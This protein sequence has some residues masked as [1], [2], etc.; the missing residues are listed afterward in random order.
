MSASAQVLALSGGVG[1]AKLS[2]GLQRVLEPGGLTVLVN[3]GDDFWHMGLRI[4][5]DL[6]T[7]L[8]TLAG[9]A[10]TTQGWGRAEESFGVLQ[11]I[12]RLGFESWFR[13]GDRDL[14]IHLERTRR[15][16]QGESLT[17]IT[18]ALATTFGVSTQILP[19]CDESVST[20]LLTP[21]GWLGFQ[22]YFVRQRCEPTVTQLEFLGA[23]AAQVST[24]LE[25]CLRATELRVIVLCPSNPWL[26]IDPILA[27]PG[28]RARLRAAGVP[29]VAVSPLVGGRAVKGPTAKLMREL[30]QAVEHAAIA[31]HYADFIDGLLIDHGDISELTAAGLAGL[32][33]QRVRAVPTL[34]R[35]LDDRESL[36]RA[37]LAFADDL[38]DD[39]AMRCE[40]GI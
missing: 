1:G 39:A 3:T 7:T 28:L 2:L 12:T 26:S 38:R 10:D 6:D 19:M 36:A 27:V 20:R 29:I 34:M 9:V 33:P 25:H 37:V 11:E 35:T 32:P 14:A 16:Q 13:L 18:A 30:G 5:P 24:A 4:C 40:G 15:L 22:D 8:Y 17:D 23:S 31:A 21:D